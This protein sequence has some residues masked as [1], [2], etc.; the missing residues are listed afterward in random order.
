MDLVS[1]ANSAESHTSLRLINYRQ[2]HSFAARCR[3]HGNIIFMYEISTPRIFHALNFS[4]GGL[5]GGIPLTETHHSTFYKQTYDTFTF[6]VTWGLAFV[7]NGA[8][9]SFR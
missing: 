9:M 7:F 2:V 8:H 1:R 4:N 5:L 6:P 3:L